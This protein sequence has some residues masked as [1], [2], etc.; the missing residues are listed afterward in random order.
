MSNNHAEQWQTLLDKFTTA[1]IANDGPGLAA[2]FT[3]DGTYTDYIYG[4]FTGP[5]EIARLLND[6]FH[7]DGE[8]YKWDMIDPVSDGKTGYARYLFSFT[9]T[10]P[11][12]AGNRVVLEGTTVAKLQDGLIAHYH[13]TADA[14]CAMAQLGLP[15]EVM[16]R[17]GHKNAESLLARG[18]SQSHKAG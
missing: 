4:D 9:S 8:D 7:G 1:I 10:M 15:A 2:C 17:R 5:S 3:P 18:E 12:Y 11:K 16:Y 13:E 14:I 6:F